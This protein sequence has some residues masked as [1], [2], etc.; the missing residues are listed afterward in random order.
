MT[1]P[2]DKAKMRRAAK[3]TAVTTAITKLEALLAVSVDER[4][5]A[6]IEGAGIS[7]KTL[8]DEIKSYD[9]DIFDLIEV[10][11]ELIADEKDV[12]EYKRKAE[13]ARIKVK[14]CLRKSGVGTAAKVEDIERQ[15]SGMKLPKMNPISFSGEAVKWRS[16][17]EQFD[18]SVHKNSK[19]STI[20]KLTYLKSYLKGTAAEALECL[21]IIED[22]YL[23]AREIL[24]KRF[25]NK[26]LIVSTH[27]NTLLK[28][29]EVRNTNVKEL[30]SLFDKIEANVRALSSLGVSRD[31]FGPL[32]IPII[33][34]KLPDMIRLQVTRVLGDINEW[35]IDDFLTKLG[36]EITARESYSFLK[37]N[38][39]EKIRHDEDGGNSN[40][41]RPAVASL[42]GNNRTMK[43]VFCNNNNHY[44][45]KCNVVTDMKKRVDI[46]QNG[47]LCFRCLRGRHPAR[48]C[49]AT[50][51]CFKC[52]ST[53]HHTAICESDH[54]KSHD[55]KMRKQKDEEVPSSNNLL[56][57]NRDSVMLQTIKVKVA[58]VQ[59]KSTVT[60][61]L[62]LD[63]GSQR[64]YISERL[65]RKLNL[66]TQDI[67]EMKISSFGDHDGKIT[68]V[69][70]HEFC[71]KSATNGNFYL[72]G[73]AMPS[74][75]APLHQRLDLIKAKFE[76][77]G[78][79]FPSNERPEMNDGIIDILIGADYYW[80]LVTEDII[81]LDDRLV[82]IRS[83]LGYILS[84]PID[85]SDARNVHS[86]NCVHVMHTVNTPITSTSEDDEL[87]A[88]M[89]KMWDLEAIGINSNEDTMSLYDTIKDDITYQSDTGRYEV[90]LPFKPNLPEMDDDYRSSERSLQRLKKKLS[91]EN[92]L[93]SYDDIIK[94]QLQDGIIEK[95]DETSVNEIG[96]V[97]Y[98]PHRPVINKK[99]AT[100]K[101]RI[102]YN[103]SAKR[104][105]KLSL[106]ECLY[107]GECT[108]PLIFGCLLRFRVH[109]V[110]LVAD[111]EGAYLQISVKPE[112]RDFLRFLWYSDIR[113]GDDEIVKL[114]FARVLF[115]LTPSQFLLNSVIRKH[116]ESYG[117]LEF[118]EKVLRSF[119][120]DDLGTS[121]PTEDMAIESYR[122]FKIRF[123][124]AGFNLRKFR[125]NNEEVRKVIASNEVQF[126]EITGSKVLGLEW[127]EVGD[128]FIIDMLQFISNAPDD[129]FTRR[130]L[131]GMIASFYDPL[132]MIQFWVIQLK[133]LFQNA[134]RL[135]LN[136]DDDLPVG[137]E[138]SL[139]KMIN[140]IRLQK[141]YVIPR[142]YD[143]RAE[144]K[145]T[146]SIDLIGFSDASPSAYGA[147]VYVRIEKE[148][149]S[150]D[151][152]LV[153]SKSRVAPIKNKQ[154][155]PRLEL[156]GNLVLSRLITAVLK[157]FEN[158]MI[159]NSIRCY[160]DSKIC[161][162]WLASYDKQYKIFVQNRVNEIRRSEAKNWLYCPSEQ[163]PA[164]LLTK[165][166]SIS[167]ENKE[168]WFSGPNFLRDAPNGILPQDEC[169]D[170]PES[171]E[172]EIVESVTSIASQQ[173]EINLIENVIDINRYSNLLKLYRVT[174]YVK[175]FINNVKG[176]SINMN[177]YLSAKEIK[178]AENLWVK[179]NQRVLINDSNYEQLKLQLNCSNDPDGI[180]R[181]YGRMKNV[182]CINENARAPIMLSKDHHLST[183]IVWYCHTKV[184][185]R[186]TRQTLNELRSR[187]WVTRGRSFVRKI[188]M[189]CT[190]CKRLNS[191]PFS[192]PG[193][194]DLP[195]LRFDNRHPFASVGCDYLGPLYVTPVY[196]RRNSTFKA[197]VVIYT[198]ASTRAVIL[199]VV[200]AADT[201][202]FIQCFRRFIA[203]RG[204][205]SIVISDNGPSFVA[206]ET[207]KFAADRFVSWKFNVASAPNWGGMWERL[208]SCVKKCL[209]KVIGVRQVTFVELQT[210]ICEIEMI[211]N[212]RPI[213]PDYDDDTDEVLTPNHLVFGHRLESINIY[214]N[215]ESTEE[216]L[217]KRQ[218][219]LK[220]RLKHFW[221][222]W[223]TEYLSALRET[224]KS[225]T[226][227]KSIPIGLD[228]VV[229]IHEDNVPR[230]R[231][232][233]GRVNELLPGTD[234]Q[235]RAAKLQTS[236]GNMIT[237][238]LY[239]LYPL[240]SVGRRDADVRPTNINDTNDD[241]N[242]FTMQEV[243]RR[244]AS[245]RAELKMKYG[246]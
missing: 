89:N 79:L 132:G 148:D 126:E 242:E 49:N 65:A 66:P 194:S 16:F 73:Y 67:G 120:V 113:N 5:L 198:C 222:I 231:W 128:V 71:V 13:V 36:N 233:L 226:T 214:E 60:C 69:K 168:L 48:N 70:E 241:N 74:I 77:F 147:C 197:Y 27:M 37:N 108:T 7:I 72:K 10:E 110:A 30:R 64:T 92:L 178:D 107:K 42:F 162:A 176:K 183:L 236:S 83:K 142:C 86:T 216:T 88:K 143:S 138:V 223:Q 200:S 109:R 244:D 215:N 46:I 118:L 111:I 245:I 173:T 238:P 229:I 243:P 131:L 104:K 157:G 156:L 90:G 61:N 159:F 209:K 33:L 189:P 220:G 38:G 43:C 139:R 232:S 217:S 3:R 59:D 85:I 181:T 160:T 12:Q 81:R 95:V 57:A 41:G 212:N 174:A 179:A 63:G 163:N 21:P 101:I 202:T 47:R 136:W 50:V 149:G 102:V 205:P 80:K 207:Q 68:S 201:P 169:S 153:A 29:K 53:T 32:L 9:D 112:H 154:T 219:H 191:R 240:E 75:C 2:L 155:I 152:S 206:D 39:N 31:E 14:E 52:Q 186:G 15:V 203:R 221:K 116:A 135:K 6:E 146:V 210:L 4:E 182:T 55:E 34:E 134:T 99:K 140:E 213:S 28:L 91:N 122:Q 158:L 218:R 239:K 56:S 20:E 17:I 237:R 98:I 127:D 11:A 84:G 199:E 125:T 172:E 175:R 100:T 185:H 24:E 195:E 25:G 26:Q 208:V 145:E 150:I 103:A 167:K 87:N 234:G 230:Q 18:A 106:N 164:D 211:L 192:Y 22:N 184:L 82:A 170:L 96:T 129:K 94:K 123:A 151:V 124:A 119:Y 62:L 196:G 117:D 204:C 114:R 76:E 105:G 166:R 8:S 35:K 246:Q 235:I 180:V 224:H 23:E 97:R 54:G 51:K 115:G 165:I 227:K 188:I 141:Q 78:H 225:T 44:S 190:V 19:L 171:E 144:K 1:T 40:G 130:T 137:I 121:V 58:D 133:I 187:Y 93:E 228:D 161:L 193:H 177:K 45:D